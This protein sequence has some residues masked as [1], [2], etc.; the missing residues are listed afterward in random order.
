MLELNVASVQ[1]TVIKP[2]SQRC[3]LNEQSK[4]NVITHSD[5]IC[6]IINAISQPAGKQAGG[7]NILLHI[8]DDDVIAIYSNGYGTLVYTVLYHKSKWQKTSDHNGRDRRREIVK[9]LSADSTAS[10]STS[11]SVEASWLLPMTSISSCSELE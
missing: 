3:Q 4:G 8:G 10:S 6:T 2:L 7:A 11:E 9:A 5:N 1:C